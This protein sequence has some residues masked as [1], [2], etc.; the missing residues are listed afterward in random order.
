MKRPIVL[1]VLILGLFNLLPYL[2]AQDAA[3]VA[4]VV[5]IEGKVEYR[6]ASGKWKP[7]KLGAVLELGTMVSTGFKSTTT[8]KLGQD[9]IYVKPVTRLSLEEL[10]RTEGGTRTKLFLTV[11]RVKADVNPEKKAKVDFSIK[12]ATAT[13]SVRGT[14]FE[15]DGT[16]LV[17]AHGMVQLENSW[18]QYRYVGGGE[19]SKVDDDNSISIPVAVN[20]AN[21]LEQLDEINDQVESD[22]NVA[23]VQGQ[24]ITP[25]AET[26]T[27]IIDIE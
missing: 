25:I 5:E 11:G 8:L 14:S 20:P 10:V 3:L 21:G 15:T 2:A 27:L 1:A 16:N 7:L 6:D 4:T 19:Y 26:G 23:I 24:S 18:G 17:V 9:S 13:A 12:S 22:S